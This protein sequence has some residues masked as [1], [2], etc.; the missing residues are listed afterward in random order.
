[1]E[2][3][4]PVH[5]VSSSLVAA[6]DGCSRLQRRWEVIEHLAR[7]ENRLQSNPT[8]NVPL[9]SP[10]FLG[11]DGGRGEARRLRHKLYHRISFGRMRG[12]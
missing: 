11:R 9:M 8:R 3:H 5:L 7:F 10:P 6:T 12:A 1:M 4:S 2:K